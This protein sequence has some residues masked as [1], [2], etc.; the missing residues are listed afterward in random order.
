MTTVFHVG[1]LNIKKPTR[2]NSKP[3]MSL[4]GNGLSVSHHPDEWTKIARLGG[5]E[6][7]VL[8][9]SSPNF[10]MAVESGD[11]E[12]IRWCI[13]EGYLVPKKK[14]RAYSTDEDGEEHFFELDSKKEAEQESDDVR[15]VNGYSFGLKGI[16]YWRENF[17]SK[18]DNSM[19]ASFAAIFFAEAHGYDGVWWNEILKVSLLSAPRGVIFQHKLSEWKIELIKPKNKRPDLNSP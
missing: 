16:N 1:F 7:Y 4:E 2:G 18:V 9:K 19:A 13:K 14:Y 12:S 10:F 3:G 5:S 11:K 17:S 15:I 8:T 6:T